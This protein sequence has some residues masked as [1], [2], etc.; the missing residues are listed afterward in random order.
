[1][2]PVA[3]GSPPS[4]SPF[5]AFKLLLS[6]FSPPPPPTTDLSVNPNLE[7]L[8][9][10]IVLQG[11]SGEP[12]PPS[13]PLPSLLPPAQVSTYST[14]VINNIETAV[15]TAASAVDGDLNTLQQQ[16]FAIS[17]DVANSEAQ[18]QNK[19]F[20]NFDAYAQE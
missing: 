4:R 1:L 16:I 13:P 19:A 9:V 15:Q 7:V 5:I 8:E 20:S 3:L 11:G 17:Q 6:W 12:A 10:R 2:K 14:Q 18:T